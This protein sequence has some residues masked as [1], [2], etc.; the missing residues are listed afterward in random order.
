[1]YHLVASAKSQGGGGGR[2]EKEQQGEGIAETPEN[3]NGEFEGGLD[4]GGRGGVGMPAPSNDT[5][6]VNGQAVKGGR[7]GGR[8]KRCAKKKTADRVL[9]HIHTHAHTHTA[10]AEAHPTSTHD[11]DSAEIKDATH[12]T[13]ATCTTPRHIVEA[14]A[15]ANYA[16]VHKNAEGE[17]GEE[18][19]KGVMKERRGDEEGMEIGKGEGGVGGGGV[20]Y[21]EV[22]RSWATT[23]S[24]N[25][26]QFKK[27]YILQS[28][29]ATQFT[30]YRVDF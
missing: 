11:A 7:G 4:G 29:I 19:G 18:T 9:T 30:N 23:S 24:D 20:N 10:M 1:V 5:T 8:E 21:G 26:V 27:V 12:L 2:G 14:A 6:L 15:P 17:T 28:Q 25:V 3:D 22:L 16:H 13:H